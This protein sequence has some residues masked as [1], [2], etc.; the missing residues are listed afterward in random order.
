[1]TDLYAPGPLS[2][3]LVQGFMLDVQIEDQVDDIGG[4]SVHRED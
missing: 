4:Q 3:S 2:D 1:M